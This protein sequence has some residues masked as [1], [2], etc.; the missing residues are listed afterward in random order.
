MENIINLE[1]LRQIISHLSAVDDTWTGASLAV[2]CSRLHSA[3][4]WSISCFVRNILS[5]HE[6]H[7]H[8]DVVL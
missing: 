7:Q 2:V 5:H 3:W 4:A 1:F 6:L 8:Q